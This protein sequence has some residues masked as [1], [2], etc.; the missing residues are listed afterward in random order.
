VLRRIDI[1]NGEGKILTFVKSESLKF[2]TEYE[3]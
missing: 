1:I 2:L 3:R